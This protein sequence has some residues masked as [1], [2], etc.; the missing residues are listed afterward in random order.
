MKMSVHELAAFI[1]Y[2]VTKYFCPGYYDA[3]INDI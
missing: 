2:L 1:Q 3:Y